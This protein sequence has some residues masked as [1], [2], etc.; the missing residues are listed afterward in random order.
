MSDKEQGGLAKPKL[1]GTGTPEWRRDY[2]A[3]N[4]KLEELQSELKTVKDTY[5]PR[6]WTNI[7]ID[8]QRPYSLHSNVLNSVNLILGFRLDDFYKENVGNDVERAKS[9]E[10]ERWAIKGALEFAEFL[11]GNPQKDIVNAPL[12][13]LLQLNES[14]AGVAEFLRKMLELNSTPGSPQS[15]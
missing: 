4:K 14:R 9:F 15:L 13:T 5:L 8:Q 11:K 7:E 3:L 10:D 6:P 1:Q 12:S 2:H